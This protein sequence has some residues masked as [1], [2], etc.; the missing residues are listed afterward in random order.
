MKLFNYLIVASFFC[1]IALH[2][3][4]HST[5]SGS[6]DSNLLRKELIALYGDKDPVFEFYESRDFSSFWL[7]DNKNLSGLIEA[8]NILG[9]N[10]LLATFFRC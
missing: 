1:F 5:I 9:P 6:V 3:A 2:S 7:S 4:A 10:C 8:L